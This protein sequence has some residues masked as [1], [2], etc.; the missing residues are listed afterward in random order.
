MSMRDA[1]KK[2]LTQGLQQSI[3][4]STLGISPS[5]I[6]QLMGEEDFRS[7]VELALSDRAAHDA[8]HDN[9]LDAIEQKATEQLDKLMPFITDPMKL[10]K[11]MQTMNAAKRRVIRTDAASNSNSH[12]LQVNIILPTQVVQKLTVDNTNN[13]V[14]AIGEQSLLPVTLGQLNAVIS[15]GQD[16][17]KFQAIPAPI[18]QT[19]TINALRGVDEVLGAD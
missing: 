16:E 2:L 15:N 14:V 5:Y 11:I 17:T 18:N 6:S 3:V 7:E 10:M 19:K 13:Q 8:E 12:G 1:V 4:A 9:L